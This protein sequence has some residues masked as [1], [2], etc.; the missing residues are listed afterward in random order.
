MTT[1][2]FVRNVKLEAYLIALAESGT[3][4]RMVWC[5]LPLLKAFPY[6]KAVVKTVED[7]SAIGAASIEKGPFALERVKETTRKIL[8]LLDVDATKVTAERFNAVANCIVVNAAQ[9]LKLED[10]WMTPEEQKA[11]NRRIVAKVQ[12]L[13]EETLKA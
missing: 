3:D 12:E 7:A 4:P 8:G 5:G 9:V 10:C 2:E 6:T 13:K 11:T 1:D